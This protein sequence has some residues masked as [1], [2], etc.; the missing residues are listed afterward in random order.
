VIRVQELRIEPEDVPSYTVLG[1]DHRPILP[2]DEHLAYLTDLNYSPNTVRA[3]A[4]DLADFFRW[5]DQG[6]RDW[7]RVELTDIGQWAG[8]LRL[9]NAARA[10]VVV[11][12]PSVAA[13]VTERS[14]DR[15]L[16]AVGSFYGFHAQ[17]DPAVQ[18]VFSRWQAGASRAGGKPFL[19]HVQ[20]GSWR[21]QI[22]LRGV[23]DRGPMVL[24]RPQVAALLAACTRQRDRFLLSLLF[25]TGMRAG[26]ALGLRHSDLRV[27]TSE[28]LVRPRVNANGARVKGSKPRSIPVNA[29]LFAQ[30]A[31]YMGGEY[32][33]CD[34]DYV[35]VQLWRGRV[36]QAMTY[37]SLH[38]LV[39]RLR[40]ATGIEAFTPH[41]LRHTYATELIRRG[42]D[43][44]VVQRLL[45]HASVQTTL[46]V[47]GHL[48]AEDARQALVAAGWIIDDEVQP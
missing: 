26:E 34:S 46:N 48:T 18:V 16:A 21:R 20:T 25:E 12:L 28:V 41:Q 17:R 7:R 19:A 5:L 6:G 43:W 40:R 30:Y 24:T 2:V 11:V 36:G 44:Q 39:G 37:D 35:F 15:K 1:Q 4:H 38:S 32:G 13:A 29:Q 10:G 47:Y 33:S 14:I 3:Y 23:V 31:D 22:R 8:W 42:T 27:A 9:P 45:G